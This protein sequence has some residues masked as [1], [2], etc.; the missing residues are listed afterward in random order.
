MNQL[1]IF[2]GRSN[3]SLAQKIASFLDMELGNIE[4]GNF[5]DGETKIK[6]KE[7]IRG[8]DV[9]IIQSISYPANEHLME[10][11]LMIDAAVRASADRVTAVIP[12]YGYARQDRKVEPRVPISAKLVARLLESAG[13][14]RILTMDL[15]ADQIQGFFNIPVDQLYSLEVGI[16][17]FKEL[18]KGRKEPLCIVS[19]DSGGAERA[20]I[21]AKY[22]SADFAIVDKRRPKENE[23][24]VLN[25][26]GDVEGKIVII[27]DDIIDTAGTIS[28]SAKILKEKGALEIY[29][30]AT[31]GVFSGK[32]YKRMM[33]AGFQRIVVTDTIDITKRRKDEDDISELDN[34]EVVSVASLFAKAINRIH[35]NESV[36]SL[37]LNIKV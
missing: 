20:R 14:N 21:Y 10:L 2:S 23:A 3:P 8:R 36:S 31:H 16:K 13:A 1:R 26:V 18:L 7:N 33:E 9:F 37:F 22:L 11:L 28:K 19:P 24:E 32:A 12:Y 35:N 15:H 30:Y 25:V 6:I 27:V 29:A 34:L 5:S 17:Y 4:I